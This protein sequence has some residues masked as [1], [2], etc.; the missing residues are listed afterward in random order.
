[1]LDN[2]NVCSINTGRVM[3]TTNRQEGEDNNIDLAL[4]SPVIISKCL[5]VVLGSYGSDYSL[6]TIF[7]EKSGSRK[8]KAKVR[9]FVYSFTFL[10][11]CVHR[12]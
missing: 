8:L 3:T 10:I 9:S 7:V 5:W 12:T 11:S 4:V 1:M 6:C 2:I